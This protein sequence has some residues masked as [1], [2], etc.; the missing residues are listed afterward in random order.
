MTESESVIRSPASA[1][2]AVGRIMWDVQGRHFLETFDGTYEIPDTTLI[3]AANLLRQQGFAPSDDF[4]LAG[5]LARGVVE[6]GL[7]KRIVY[8][9]RGVS[10]PSW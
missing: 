7:I 1:C 3:E 4:R 5:I 9:A 10:V 2:W 6:G 8:L